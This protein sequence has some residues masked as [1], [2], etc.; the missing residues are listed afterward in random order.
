MIWPYLDHIDVRTVPEDFLS[1]HLLTFPDRVVV[2]NRNGIAVAYHQIPS[3]DS[4]H[5]H[6]PA[7]LK[8]LEN[9]VRELA[10][11]LADLRRVTPHA[12]GDQPRTVSGT[13]EDMR[14]SLGITGRIAQLKLAATQ[15]SNLPIRR[16]LEAMQ[17]DELAASFHALV[18]ERNARR[19]QEAD[20]T[21]QRVLAGVALLGLVYAWNQMEDIKVT[22]L[23]EIGW[24]SDASRALPGILLACLPFA[25]LAYRI[26]SGRRKL[27]R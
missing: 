21:L 1:R 8:E 20:K 2:W 18:Q 13:G 9:G 24:S 6:H 26:W 3:D 25:Y 22:R 17:F 23:L 7:A 10:R 27:E 15:S 5:G 19:D 4:R 14:L 12:T 16:L 11:V